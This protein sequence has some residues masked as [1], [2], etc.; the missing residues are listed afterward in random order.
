[1]TDLIIRAAPAELEELR[2]LIELEVGRPAKLQPVTDTQSGQMREPILIALIVALGGPALTT[3]IAGVIKRHL[4]HKEQMQNLENKHAERIQELEN[5]RRRND[6]SHQFRMSVI[7][8]DE[9]DEERPV[10]LDDLTQM[11][12]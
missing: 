6:Q 12:T 10:T 9:D 11:A 2:R 1:M 8:D 3:A 4:Q 5:E 7:A